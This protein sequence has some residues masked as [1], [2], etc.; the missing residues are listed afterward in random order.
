MFL[1]EFQLETLNTLPVFFVIFSEKHKKTMFSQIV[2]LAQQSK[3]KPQSLR[4]AQ[5]GVDAPECAKIKANFDAWN[6]FLVWAG[7]LHDIQTLGEFAGLRCTG[8]PYTLR[9][10]T[11]SLIC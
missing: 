5:G 11:T 7:Y 3:P 4:K 8:K 9:K 10:L 6:N 1:Y 2:G